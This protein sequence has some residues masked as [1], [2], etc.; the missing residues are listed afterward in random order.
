MGFRDDAGNIVGFDID[1][2][3]SMQKLGVELVVEPI[4]WIAKE[5]ELN[6]K[7]IDLS[8]MIFFLLHRIGWSNFQCLYHIWR[9][10]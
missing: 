2:A 8:G 10:N 7:S 9:I 6:T 1:L 3:N 4:K 5:H